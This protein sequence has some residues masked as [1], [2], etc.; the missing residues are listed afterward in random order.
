MFNNDK[1][2]EIESFS[3]GESEK[4]VI[5]KKII[6]SLTD[7]HY[8]R[9]TKY[10]RLLDFLNY[11]KKE[12]KNLDAIPYLP[13]KLFKEFE[14]KSVKEKDVV[15]ILLS[16]GTTGSSPSKIFLD[17]ENANAQSKALSMIMKTVLG[18]ERLPMLIVD[19]NPSIM[20]RKKLNARMAAIN[21][22]SIFGRD[23]A[24]LLDDNEN[25]NYKVLNNF[26]S[27]YNNKKFFIFG[28]T[29][30]VYKNLVK[31]LS[32]NLLKFDLKN[33]ILLHGGGWK[34]MEKIK[35]SNKVFKERLFKRSGLSNIH[36]YYGLVEQT[37]S[38][39][40]ECNCGYF[41]TSVFSDILIRDKNFKIQKNGS[42]G[43]IQ[44]LST[45]PTS[46]PGHSILTED[47]GEIIENHKCNCSFQGKRFLVHGRMKEAEIR[48]C[49]DV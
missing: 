47:I 21:G 18:K 13:V 40:V 22:F 7:F 41:I 31:K 5:F 38:I 6:N 20:N 19:K 2:F 24:F 10:K 49:S 36:N 34:K 44:L 3:L 14:L 45:L 32:K 39:F 1:L 29:S 9:S 23:H 11:K 25:I 16:S 17:R 12:I 28:F 43:F 4:I 26:L 15:K 27:K 48:G 30:I 37:G 8:S 35:V 33:G 42:K 46:Y